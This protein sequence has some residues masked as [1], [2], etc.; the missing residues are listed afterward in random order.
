MV[1]TADRQLI[2]K[3][4]EINGPFNLHS[5]MRSGQTAEPEWFLTVNGFWEGMSL[6]EGF[7]K[8]VVREGEA[9]DEP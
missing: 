1:R 6:E 2:I 5:T 8:V 4:D 7:V 9:I 3:E